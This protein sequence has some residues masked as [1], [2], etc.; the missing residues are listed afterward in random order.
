MS[1]VRTPASARSSRRTCCVGGVGHLVQ[2]GMSPFEALSASTARAATVCGLGDR[3]G[4]LAAGYDADI[5][6]V[7]GN[8]LVDPAAL[9]QLRAVYVRG[10][11][12]V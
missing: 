9:H 5:L 8:P 3:K 6:A 12:M 2:I 1:L 7:D 10:E 4:R 11:S